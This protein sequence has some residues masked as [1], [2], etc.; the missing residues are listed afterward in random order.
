MVDC[1]EVL[2]SGAD[3]VVSL[4]VYIKASAFK[5]LETKQDETPKAMFNEGQETPEEQLFRERK[6]SLIH[7]FDVLNLKPKRGSTLASHRNGD[8]GHED[9][10]MLTQNPSKPSMS[11]KTTKTEIVGDGEEIEVEAGEDLS[12]NELNLIYK[13]YF[14]R[15]TPIIVI[16]TCV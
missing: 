7:L 11:K 13:K 5:T 14:H 1:P 2:H 12:E 15:S 9:L 10:T 4:S 3:L 16:V 8:L 6:G